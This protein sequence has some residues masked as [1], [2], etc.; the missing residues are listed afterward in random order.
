MT[1]IINPFTGFPQTTYNGFSLSEIA[2]LMRG[3]AYDEQKQIEEVNA[4]FAPTECYGAVASLAERRVKALLEM[5]GLEEEQLMEL[6]A[7]RTS[8]RWVHFNL[9]QC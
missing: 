4:Y 6:L 7:E 1:T 5:V 8:G 3:I 9:I 2:T